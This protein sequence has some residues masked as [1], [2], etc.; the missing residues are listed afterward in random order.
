M[1]RDHVILVVLEVHSSGD[2]DIVAKPHASEGCVAVKVDAV[3][4]VAVAHVDILV[5]G[6]ADNASDE[7]LGDLDKNIIRV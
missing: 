3:G 1:L 5:R 4:Q 2:E 6:A 7:R